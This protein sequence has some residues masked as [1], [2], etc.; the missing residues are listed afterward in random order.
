MF[1]RTATAALKNH[2]VE[3]L[4]AL[5]EVCRDHSCSQ[6]SFPVDVLHN[7][8]LVKHLGSSLQEGVVVE[9]VVDVGEKLLDR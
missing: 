2:E 6:G 1:L 9:L 3:I 5:N 7:V 8:E 4:V